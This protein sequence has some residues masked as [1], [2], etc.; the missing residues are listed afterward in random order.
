MKI[1]QYL[2]LFF[3][4]IL[5]VM[6]QEKHPLKEDSLSFVKKS[7]MAHGLKNW[8]SYKALDATLNLQFGN[9]TTF[10]SARFVF[11]AH[12]PKAM[13]TNSS[14]KIVH[15]GKNCWVHPPDSKN[16]KERFHVWTWPWFLFAPMKMTGEGIYL[17]DYEEIE[18]NG[19]NYKT[20]LQTFS[21][22]SGDTPEDWYRLFINPE[23]KM[24]DAMSY[25][26]T[27]GKSKEKANEHTSIIVYKNYTDYNGVKLAKDFELWHWE[28]KELVGEKPKAVGSWFDI[29]LHKQIDEKWFHIPEGST[30]VNLP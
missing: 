28:N 11:E 18:L 12:G 17:S 15:N 26:V 20:M 6:G 22:A 10:D 13:Y 1:N 25:I 30:E 16:G 2:F 3:F 14:K 19:V 7:Q 29:E 4:S 23:T 5:P 21:D 27:Y 8:W 24:L 9:K